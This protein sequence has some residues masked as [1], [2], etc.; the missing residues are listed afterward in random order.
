MAITLTDRA[1]RTL[2]KR[3]IE[4][5]IVLEI[6]GVPTIFGG[7]TITEIIRIGDPGLEIGDDWV[8]GGLRAVDD[9]ETLI[10]LSGT[11]NEIS[12]QL[13]PDRGAISSIS[14]MKIAMIDKD[15]VL[16]RLISPGN[17]VPD[18]MARRARVRLGFANTSYP[19][20]YITIFRGIIDDIESEQGQINLNL[21]H[22][23]Q[24]KR[25]TIYEKAECVLDGA[26]NNTDV[27]INVDTTENFL[28]GVTGPDGLV[29]ASF[30]GYIKIDDEVIHYTGK[31]ATSFTGCTRGALG[32][33]ADNHNDETSA[34]SFYR[35]QGNGVELALKIL[36]SGWQGPFQEDVVVSNFVRTTG[37]IDIANSM[38]FEAVDLQELY[39]V[40]E[41]DYITTTG[42][43]NGANN[44][45]LKQIET[46]EVIDGSTYIVIAGVAFVSEIGTSAVVDFRSQYDVLPSGLKM[47]GDE[48][49]VDAHLSWFRRYLSSFD[50]D[51]YLKDT[52]E[53]KEFIET[54]LY[55][56]MGGYSLP[57]KSRASMGYH[58]GPLPSDTIVTI[59]DTNCVNPDKLKVR[60]SIGKNFYNTIIYKFDQDVLEDKFLYGFIST[61]TDSKDRIK[62]GSKSLI[63][64][65]T[66]MRKV[67]GGLNSAEMAATRLLNRYRFAAE[68][69]DDVKIKF[70]VGF[71]I[72]T[73][74]SVI[75]DGTNLNLSDTANAV[76]GAGPRLYE[77][78][79][80]K[81][82]I[83]TGEVSLSLVDS[84]ISL[85]SRYALIS[86]ASV[87]ASATDQ[88]N[89]TIESSF[90]SV[91]GAN[92]GRKWK[93]YIGCGVKIRNADFSVAGDA[94]IEN[95][96]GNVITLDANIG[97]PI[98]AGYVME[99]SHY[100]TENSTIKL[101]YTFMTDNA[102]FDDGAD[103]Y[104]MV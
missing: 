12:Q 54:Q 47:H 95:V 24:K 27:T 83:K 28:V 97:F 104:R 25:N 31:T 78:I 29:D 18:I 6:D 9:Q 43:A 42:A 30:D 69:L 101:F 13:Q 53:G 86:P 38:Y 91:Y 50:M 21:A 63:I 19:E 67:I 65:A 81:L 26:L 71:R 52:I 57:R 36:F 55:L 56:P 37:V 79:N 100:N 70:S 93:R 8:I 88:R 35:L 2:N 59:D 23:D 33:V 84:N 94:F 14:S 92:E 10:S 85:V 61:D 76:R 98:V 15:E 74:D 49:D 60:R 58:S 5:Q 48:V 17:V 87:V 32:T 102:A 44:V 11:S 96:V 22:P 40:N 82:N 45:A 66:G 68:F 39:G 4:P 7:S 73:G 75:L 16:T 46:L 72:E 80:K 103:Q 51:F 20:D 62:V 34:Q 3:L 1:E 90:A 64:E 99:L 77:V 89:F 41:G